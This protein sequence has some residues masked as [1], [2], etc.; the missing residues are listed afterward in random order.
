MS[1]WPEAKCFNVVAMETEYELSKI[2]PQRVFI[3]NTLSSQGDKIQFYDSAWP[4]IFGIYR[5]LMLKFNRTMAIHI[6]ISNE[7]SFSR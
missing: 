6:N 2:Y 5:E 3:G 7:G 1:F 4:R